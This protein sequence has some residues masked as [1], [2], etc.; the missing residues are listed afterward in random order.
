M[1]LRSLSWHATQAKLR[2]SERH[3]ARLDAVLALQALLVRTAA[4]VFHFTIQSA[5]TSRPEPS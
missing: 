1:T 5:V 2:D 4:V 3:L